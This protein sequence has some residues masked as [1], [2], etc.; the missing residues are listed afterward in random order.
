MTSAEPKN[1]LPAL[2][3]SMPLCFADVPSMGQEAFGAYRE[4]ISM[5]L[6]ATPR[7]SG[8]ENECLRFIDTGER[9]RVPVDAERL[10][11][12]SGDSPEE[13]KQKMID[14]LQM[15]LI[16]FQDLELSLNSVLNPVSLPHEDRLSIEL[17]DEL[18]AE[19]SRVL[20]G[21]QHARI[22]FDF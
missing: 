15:N 9:L 22:R 17:I 20:E 10:E 13:R 18:V 21:I 7:S 11:R 8:I 16:R 2:L 14:Y 1:L 6:G 5:G 12:M 4:L 19:Y 3:E